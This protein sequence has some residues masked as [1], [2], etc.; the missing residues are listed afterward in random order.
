[1]VHQVHLEDG[2]FDAHGA[3]EE[4]LGADDLVSGFLVDVV[5]GDEVG[6][7]GNLEGFFA[8]TLFQTGF[9]L[10]QLALD[11]GHGG[12]DGDKHIRGALRDTDDG[13][14]G[15]DG[16]L[17]IIAAF[18]HA[19]DDGGFRLGLEV[20]VQLADLFLSVSVDPVGD[21]HFLVGKGE[22]HMCQLL[23]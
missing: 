16:D 15:A 14:G 2:F 5:F 17:Q 3:E 1:M 11:G 13:G 19:E 10:T 6:V 21:V 18:L 7:V 9:I 23:S 20:A 4:T 22:F 12:V 8:Q